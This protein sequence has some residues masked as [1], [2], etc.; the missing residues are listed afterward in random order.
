[1]QAR[2]PA[3]DPISQDEVVA[4]KAFPPRTAE[5]SFESDGVK[6]YGLVFCAQGKGLHPTVLYARGFPDT[7]A[8]NDILRVLQRAG[9]NVMFF[10]YRGT[11]SM[12]GIFSMQHSYED[13]RAALS[14]L[15]QENSAKTMGVDPAAVVLYGYSWGGPIALRLAAEDS[16]IK[17]LILQDPSDLRAYSSMT[18]QALAEEEADGASPVVPTASV[19]QVID[20]LIVHPSDWDP[21]RYV[22]GL[23]GKTVLVAWASK[24]SESSEQVAPVDS[25]ATLLGPRSHFSSTIFNTDHGFTDKRIA[26]TRKYLSWLNSVVPVPVKPF[27][28]D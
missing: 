6:L 16:A 11:S 13:L 8:S 7:T 4:N 24:S 14:F 26:L 21:V 3:Y 2:R 12:G 25:L 20:G 22:E 17:A 23:S 9:Y 10:N 27:K 19:K 28:Q 5:A 1:V 18:P 15:R